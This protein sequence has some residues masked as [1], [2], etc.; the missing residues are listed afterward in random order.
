MSHAR[1][2]PKK[3]HVLFEWLQSC[4]L[5]GLIFF[6]ENYFKKLAN[7]VRLQVV[8][9]VDKGCENPKKKSYVARTRKTQH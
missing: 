6:S 1:K 5:L 4:E 7:E 9:L 2:V 3:S 8:L